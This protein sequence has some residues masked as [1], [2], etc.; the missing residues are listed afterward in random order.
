MRSYFD[1]AVN[2]EWLSGIDESVY[3]LDVVENPK[4][5]I[6]SISQTAFN[7]SRFIRKTRQSLSVTARVFI[8]QQDPQRR[9][10]VLQFVQGWANCGGRV[11]VSYR[12][13]QY[14]TAV[15]DEPPTLVS[16]NK[17]TDPLYV[18]FTAYEFPFWRS[19]DK[20]NVSIASTGSIKPGGVSKSMPCDVTITNTG[21]SEVTQL[22]VTAGETRL[23][24][25][26]VSLPAGGKLEIM[27]DESGLLS[28]KIDDVSILIN[29]TEESSDDLLVSGGVNNSISVSSD[30]S[31]SALFKA[32]GV[33]L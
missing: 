12:T 16:A 26:N 32:W 22:T 2:G 4:E 14:L 3:V 5:N 27:H 19:E 23:S 6:Y 18:V 7:G 1:I 13:G 30:G 15:C 29:R 21:N 8:A 11:E 24:F 33:Y 31:V 20:T 10:Q 17:W 28:A 25:A 9:A